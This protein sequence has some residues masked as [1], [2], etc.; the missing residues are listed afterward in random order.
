MNLKDII[1]KIMVNLDEVTS[2]NLVANSADYIFKIYPLIDTIQTEIATQVKPIEEYKTV[3]SVN[4]R[5]DVPN[6]CFEFLKVYDTNLSP[7]SYRKYNSLLYLTDVNVKDGI[8]TLYYNKYPK[9]I[10]NSSPDEA[11]L[12]IDKECQEALIY[13]VCAGLTINDEPELYDT[14]IDKYNT[15][16]SNISARLQN[17]STARLVG[18]LRL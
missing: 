3:E 1:G 9:F 2:S 8:Y 5:M 10:N 15:M 16:I 12:E 11:E 18:G 4:K 6:D 17:N 7:I 13:G 14:Y